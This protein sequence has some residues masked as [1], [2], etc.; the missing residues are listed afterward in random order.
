MFYSLS[1]SCIFYLQFFFFGLL[2]CAPDIGI[3]RG[4]VFSIFIWCSPRKLIESPMFLC[5]L[6][7]EM[8]FQKYKVDKIH[9]HRIF[10]VFAC[11]L[12]RIVIIFSEFQEFVSFHIHLVFKFIDCACRELNIKFIALRHIFVKYSLQFFPH[13]VTRCFF[14][15]L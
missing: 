9:F 3:M 12:N 8:E 5:F 4:S 7:S 13:S 11:L 2:F 6:F 15:S 1:S 10:V 14:I